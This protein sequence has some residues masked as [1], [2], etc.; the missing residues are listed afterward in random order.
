MK[1]LY[2]IA[3]KSE[4]EQAQK[5]GAYQ[6]STLGKTLPEAGYIHLSFA[7][8]VKTVADALYKGRDDLVL[9]TINPEKLESNFYIEDAPG[10]AEKYPHLYGALNL[11]AVEEVSPYVSEADGEFPTV[12]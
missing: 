9:L 12:V 10:I 7:H 6:M 2:H 3:V 4:W 5:A 1:M 8:Q 11:D